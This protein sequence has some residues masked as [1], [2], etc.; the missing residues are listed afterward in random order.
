MAALRADG[1]GA[2]RLIAFA[3]AADPT[4][5]QIAIIDVK[6]VINNFPVEKSSALLGRTGRIGVHRLDPEIE[7][8]N[9]GKCDR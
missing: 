7:L 3:F 9:F 1:I 6:I 2:P 5:H 4:S 8:G